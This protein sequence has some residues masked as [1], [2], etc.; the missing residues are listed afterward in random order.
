MLNYT[1]LND[2]EFEYLCND[3]MSKKLGIELQRFTSGRDGGIDLTNDA[4]YKNIIVQVK[5][6][7]K[8][9]VDGLIRSLSKEVSKVEKMK[10]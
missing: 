3:I 6:Y 5:H 1:N 7:V 4:F 9:D 10:P 2:V 8:T